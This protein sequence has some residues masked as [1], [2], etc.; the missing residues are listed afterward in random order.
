MRA[1][2][3]LLLVGCAHDLP[4]EQ[5][6]LEVGWAIAART[7]ECE[8]DAE[9]GAERFE[10]FEAAYTCQASSDPAVDL[11]LALYECP[12]VLRNLA[13]E[14]VVT[15]GDDLTAWLSSSPACAAL[16]EPT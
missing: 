2:F 15:Y 9:L 8:G 12:L 1:A 13:C 14:L 16:L 6:C 11:E 3:V 7:S 5:A 10:A 4:D